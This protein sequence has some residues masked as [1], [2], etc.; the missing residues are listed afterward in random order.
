MSPTTSP[1]SRRSTEDDVVRYIIVV[2]GIGQQKKN[3]TVRPV[4]QRFAQARSRERQMGDPVTLGTLASQLVQARAGDFTE[5]LEERWVEFEGIPQ[6]PYT[7]PEVP[8]VGRPTDHGRNLRFVDLHWASVT[9][10]QF[11]AF[12]E[13][14]AEWTRSLIDR[15]EI[16]RSVERQGPGRGADADQWINQWIQLLRTIRDGVLPLQKILRKRNPDLTDTIFNRFLG[17]VQLYGE[18]LATRGM[19]VRRFHTRLARLEAMHY[20]GER[21]TGRAPRDP[22]YIVIAHSLGSVMSFDAL[23]CA[24]MRRDLDRDAILRMLPEYDRDPSAG[25]TS[26]IA[27]AFPNLEWIRHVEAFVTLGSP[28]DKYLGLWSLNYE[29]LVPT[30]T[31]WVDEPL[32]KERRR[33]PHYNYCDEQDPVGHNLDVAYSPGALVERVFTCEEDIVYTRYSVPGVAHVGYWNDAHLFQRILYLTVDGGSKERA[34]PVQWFSLWVYIKSLAWSYLMVPILGWLAASAVLIW[35][36]RAAQSGQT[37][38]LGVIVSLGA[39]LVTCWLMRL[40]V[41]WREIVI[42]RGRAAAEL[43]GRQRTIRTLAQLV[44]R[45]LVVVLPIVWLYLLIAAIG[46]MPLPSAEVLAKNAKDG[47]PL[48]PATV[49]ALR[50][51]SRGASEWRHSIEQWTHL[52]WGPVAW[53]LTSAWATLVGWM[54]RTGYIAMLWASVAWFFSGSWNRVDWAVAALVASAFGFLIGLWNLIVFARI[55]W[56]YRHGSKTMNFVDYVSS[57]PTRTREGG[58]S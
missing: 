56:T 27:K 36:L 15:L 50:E 21:K 22:A 4:I 24:H 11:E 31:G 9:D 37:R 12:G 58:Q 14:V 17:D 23:L 45:A 8:F 33:I 41:E 40:I 52:L 51:L 48:L 49:E 54:P 2:H 26:E 42:T 38:A 47:P 25:E 29:H 32:L 43:S 19:A 1:R 44:F 55:R 7:P 16:R 57:D 5:A 30:N 10:N 46:A 3:E 18:Y 53:A 6:R 35:A 20:E 39:L 34:N 28:I 13:P